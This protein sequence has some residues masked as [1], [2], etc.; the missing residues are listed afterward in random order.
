MAYLLTKPI[1]SQ[2]RN[3]VDTNPILIYRVVLLGAVHHFHE[4]TN[5]TLGGEGVRTLRTLFQII[6]ND[7]H[8]KIFFSKCVSDV[9]YIICNAFLA[10]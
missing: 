8:K 9:P 4:R 7:D 2:F 6:K 1:P 10:F 3:F 5:R